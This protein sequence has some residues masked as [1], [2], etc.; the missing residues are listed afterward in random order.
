MISRYSPRPRHMVSEAA[1]VRVFG[2][3]H[4][5][6]TVVAHALDAWQHVTRRN[7]WRYAW[8]NGGTRMGGTGSLK[9][10]G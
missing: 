6:H 1:V 7:A 9:K 3:R 8:R 10:A 2:H 5:L 4:Q